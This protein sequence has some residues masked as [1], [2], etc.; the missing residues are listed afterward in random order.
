MYIFDNKE[1][2]SKEILDCISSN[3][4][5]VEDLYLGL[6]NMNYS[7]ILRLRIDS[8]VFKRYVEAARLDK[9][10]SFLIKINVHKLKK[11]I[12]LMEDTS[13]LDYYDLKLLTDMRDSLKTS[14]GKVSSEALDVVN[15]VI[16]KRK[17]AKKT[18]IK[19]F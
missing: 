18:L 14:K 3:H 10:L 1:M 4:Y 13:Y 16:R 9:V 2:T 5:E 6:K 8:L 12:S 7:D 19:R 15:D 17:E 11:D